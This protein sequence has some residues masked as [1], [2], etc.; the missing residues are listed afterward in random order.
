VSVH[1]LVHTLSER[2]KCNVV[3]IH[4]DM[5]SILSVGVFATH[6]RNVQ[7]LDTHEPRQRAEDADHLV[8]PARVLARQLW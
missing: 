7:G 1:E 2:W 3:G 6:L 4:Y 5:H 8:G